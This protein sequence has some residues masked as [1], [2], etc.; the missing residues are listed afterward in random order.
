[1]QIWILS[2]ATEKIRTSPRT[3][4]WRYRDFVFDTHFEVLQARVGPGEF[5]TAGSQAI[6]QLRATSPSVL[7]CDFAGALYT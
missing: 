5:V 6:I 7:D 4:S 2:Q 1:M 3:F